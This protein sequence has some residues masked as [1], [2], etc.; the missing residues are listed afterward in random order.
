MPIFQ[1][2]FT[3]FSLEII[4]LQIYVKNGYIFK[5]ST[6]KKKSTQCII[7]FIFLWFSQIKIGGGGTKCP[8]PSIITKVHLPLIITKVKWPAITQNKQNWKWCLRWKYYSYFSS[9]KIIIN[10]NSVKLMHATP[11]KHLLLDKVWCLAFIIPEFAGLSL[12]TFR[13]MVRDSSLIG[14]TLLYQ[15]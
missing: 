3:N 15:P 7:L 1:A 4:Y 11:R 8:P 13:H 6:Q 12:V 5:T 9:S 2:F 14:R 10:L